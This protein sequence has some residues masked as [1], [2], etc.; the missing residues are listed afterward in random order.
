MLSIFMAA[1]EVTIVSTAMPTIVSELGGFRL[2]SWVFAV[3]L[4]A[5]GVSTPL[6]G[7]LADLYG[8]KPVFVV[9][10]FVFLVG[11]VACGFARQMFWLVLFRIFQGLGAGSIQ[12]LAT[13]IVGDI[14][15]ADQ[16]AKVQGWLSGVWG[17]AAIAGP[18]LGAFIVQHLHWAYVFWINLPIG[19][20]AI[21]IMIVCLDETVPKKHHRIDVLGAGLLTLGASAI[22][23]AAVAGTLGAPISAMLLTIGLIALVLLFI[24]ERRATE[25]IV[26]FQLWRDRIMAIGNIGSLIVGALLMCVVAFLPT[27]MQGVMGRSATIAGAIIGAQSLSWSI[28]SIMSGRV[29]PATSY[30]TTGVMGG[31]A[32]IAGASCLIFLDRESGLAHLV[33]VAL[34][35]G[36]GMGFCNQT[37]LIAVQSSVGWGER[38]IATASILFAR[39]IGQVLGASIGG[40]ILNFGVAHLAPGSD[41]ALNRLL[42]PALRGSVD[43]K[44]ALSFAQAIGTSLHNVFVIAALLA[45]LTLAT[46][47]LMPA[48]FIGTQGSAPREST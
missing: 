26:P 20:T 22:L 40:T 1:V 21:G 12:A 2:F 10:I 9:G 13:T 11:S 32:L 34:L 30:R 41:Q 23:V 18:A 15:A 43:A 31:I 33:V 38:G 16:R 3:Y 44:T 45:I 4:L 25:P 5:Q 6:Y 29:I 8:R 36:L 19:I 42:D 14:Y 27:Y 46:T 35:I 39:T 24:Q 28:G 17:L 48:R 37:F 7:R 47:L